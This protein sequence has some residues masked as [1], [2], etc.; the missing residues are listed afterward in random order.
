[1]KINR[2]Y[3]IEGSK[4]SVGVAVIIDIFRA[5]N[6]A[7]YALSQNAEKILPVA[8][9]DDAYALKKLYP[10][11]ILVG[12]VN[13]YKPDEFDFGNSP[14]ELSKVNLENKTIVHRSSQGTQGLVNARNADT[15]I[16]GSFTVVSSIVDFVK[17]T[18]PSV[19]SIV[20]MDGEHSEDDLF[21]QYLTDKLDDKNPSMD[22]IIETL[23]KNPRFEDMLNPDVKQ[24]PIEDFELCLS[25]DRFNFLPVT[26]RENGQLVVRKLS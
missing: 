14:F 9:I 16:F 26:K 11:Y 10:D 13:G 21:A 4:K 17:K 18:N 25:V 22:P 23:K 20:A 24:F 8:T 2:L 1:M 7:A 12:E 15:I 6:V 3:G 19:L 5:A